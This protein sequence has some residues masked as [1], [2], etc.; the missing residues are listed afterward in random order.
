MNNKRFDAVKWVV[1]V[2]FAAGVA[3]A[4]MASNKTELIEIKSEVRDH[5]RAIVELRRD[6]V[7]IRQGMDELLERKRAGAR[8]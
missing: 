4:G 6:V 2:V 5:D 8:P 7:Y 1:A 3:Y